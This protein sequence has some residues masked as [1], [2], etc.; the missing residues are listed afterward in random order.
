MTTTL[1]NARIALAKDMGDYWASATTSAG[2]AGGTTM[3][4]TALKNKSNDW[5]TNDTWDIIT[6]AAHAALN[7]ERLVA[8]LD[9][10]TGTPTLNAAHSVQIGSGI[11][12]ELHRVGSP[13]DKRLALIDAAKETFPFLYAKVRNQS[14][15]VGNWLLNGDVEKWTASTEPDSWARG[16]TITA[17]QETTAKL[18]TRGLSSCKLSASTSGYLYQSWTENDDLKFLRGHTVHF[19]AKGWCNTASALRLAIYDGTTTT[20]CS[21]HDGDSAWTDLDQDGL[22]VDATISETATDVSLRVYLDSA[23]ATAYVDDLQATCGN[24]DKV[25][26]GD[27]SIALNKGI[28]VSYQWE[29]NLQAEPWAILRTF[30]LDAANGYLYLP[31]YLSIGYHLRIEGMGYLDFLASGA[32]STAWTATIAVDDPQLKIL[33]AKA[34]AIMYRKLSQPIYSSGDRT[35]FYGALGYWER[36]FERRCTQFK[37]HREP[38]LVNY[39]T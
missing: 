29:G 11:D 21:Y 32:A 10:S 39:G 33:T 22:Y 24:Y 19:R 17:A 3:I 27:L 9:N 14:K 38:V 5:I 34:A 18:F 23:T 6:E 37:M 2:N 8:S 25:Y 7:E 4:D 36:E 20:Y 16:G 12:Y 26:V 1:A 35:S 13:S 31:N 28:R 15:T 30:N